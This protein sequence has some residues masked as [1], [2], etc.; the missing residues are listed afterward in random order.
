[1]LSF[2]L[3]W[4][5]LPPDFSPSHA[6]SPLQDATLVYQGS[7]KLTSDELVNILGIQVDGSKS[8]KPTLAITNV[9]IAGRDTAEEEVFGIIFEDMDPAEVTYRLA[10]DITNDG[11]VDLLDVVAAQRWYHTTAE[12]ENWADAAYSDVNL[13][14][15]VDIQDYVL[16]VLN[17]NEK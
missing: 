17:Y 4:I 8:Q 14:G 10:Y 16:I 1:M 3:V 5:T 6:C 15:V 7:E 2:H 11:K 13:D 9:V 12:D